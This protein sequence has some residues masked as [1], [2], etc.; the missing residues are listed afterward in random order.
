[1]LSIPAEAVKILIDKPMVFSDDGDFVGYQGFEPEVLE[2]MGF[3]TIA[4]YPT[5][6][7]GE[8]QEEAL[9]IFLTLA[10]AGR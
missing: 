4:T 7:A 9:D 5:F 3:V 6:L 8:V 1:L 10:F 2:S